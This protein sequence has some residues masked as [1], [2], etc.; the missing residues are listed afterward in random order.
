MSP[1]G[2]L[3]GNII[4]ASKITRDISARKLVAEALRESEERF[5][6]VANTAPVMI[7]LSGPD[8]LCTYFNQ[9]W[10]D[11]T[12]Q[13][14][15][16]ELGNGWADGVYPDDLQRCLE[17]YTKAFDHR[18]R[19]QMEFRLRR[20]DGEYRWI[21]DQ[22]VPRFNVDGSFVGYIGSC[23]DVTDR[24]LAEEAL[25]TVSRRLIEAHEEERTWLAREL[26]DDIN[27]RIALLAASLPHLKQSI[28]S[29]AVEASS[30]IDDLSDQATSLGLDVQALS[31]HLHS[32]KLDYLGLKTAAAGFCREFS[33]QHSLEID[34]R[35]DEIPKN[36]PKE[37]SLCL[38]RVLQ[39][40]LQNAM[41]HS[42]SKQ[43]QVTLAANQGEIQLAVADSGRGF[44]PEA[45]F[46]GRGL[47]LSNMKER[48]KLVHGHFSIAGLPEGG[49][50]V[51]VRVPL[52]TGIA[53]THEAII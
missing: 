46:R 26:H 11:F 29:S 19:F 36:L 47:G 31:H 4:G 40:A 2:D 41:K 23:L 20:H 53:T 10:L 7:W 39:E 32:S 49:T 14:L 5:R 34:F 21:F 48:L 6:L 27:Q 22:G 18:E 44:D 52:R 1:I 8:K 16:A 42:G 15:Q 30:K 17:T 38:F 13:P 51:S 28:P 3:G 50:V 9:T 25:S 45:A 35:A 24:R 37:I 33:N 43:I 12:G